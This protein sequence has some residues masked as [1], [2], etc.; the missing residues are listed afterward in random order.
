MPL[1]EDTLRIAIAGA[2]SLRGQDLKGWLEESG[3]PAGE[4]RLFDE[5]P[6]AG[7]LT[8]LAGEA[9]V[10]Q[11]IEPGSFD[12]LQFVFLAGSRAF[13]KEHGL[14]ALRAG[15][16]AVDLT[17][18]LAEMQGAELRIPRL[19]ALVTPPERAAGANSRGR[20]CIAPSAPA[21][22]ACSLAC[23]ARE[24]N[25]VRMVINFFQPV[26]ERGRAGIE[27]LEGQTVKL[28]SLQSIPQ[29]VF[30]C[31]V[32]FNMLD[33]W[34]EGS[35]ERLADARS[36]I[37]REVQLFLSGRVPV[38]ALTLIQ[39]P[40]FYG[41]A[42]SAY[43]EFAEPLDLTAMKSRLRAANFRIVAEDQPGASNLSASGESQA[44][45]T[46]GE[47]DPGVAQGYWFWGVADNLRLVTSNAVQIAEQ[48]LV[49]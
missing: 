40:V 4:V 5:E 37:V 42:F 35:S 43:A 27:E 11:P 47:R 21:I 19:D 15:A 9:A 31:Q 22:V 39:A 8:G 46:G 34:G 18:E 2:A 14:A 44:I 10:I 32:A 20:I 23:A 17:G 7:T 38:P 48:A 25:P 45:L 49:S 3:F 29:E 13:A 24:F 1:P 41:Y 12:G 30:D 28:L 26:S 6:L 16:T 36:A 33:R